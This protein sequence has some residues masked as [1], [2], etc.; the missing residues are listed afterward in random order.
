MRYHDF[1]ALPLVAGLL[2]I[3]SPLCLFAQPLD[4]A[5]HNN[6]EILGQLQHYAR[7]F[8]GWMSLD[9]I[10]H[11]AEDS[12]P[13]WC[14]K[15]SDNPDE[16]EPEAA[17]LFI[18]QVHAEEVVG[19]EL[20]LEIMKQMIENIND[21]R[22]RQRLEGLEIY[23][24][25]TANPEGL[26]VVHSGTDVTYRKNKRDNVGDGVL[27]I[28]D[29]EGWDTSGVDLNRN[30][31]MHWDRGDTLYRP[32]ASFRYNAYRGAAP[33]SEPESRA[34]R[35]L[36][37]KRPFLYSIVYHSSRS[38]ANT[39]L[40]I[41]PWYW[42]QN[43]DIK[44][45][46]DALA[47]NALGERLAD[48]MPVQNF[49]STYWYG[50]STMRKGQLQDWFYTETGCIQYMAE[51]AA[52]VHP[53]E[54]GMRQVVADQLP[55]V[56]YLMDLALGLE[57]L[58][59]F[60]TLTV[61]A[62][63][64]ETGEPLEANVNVADNQ[65]GRNGNVKRIFSERK[66]NRYNGRFDYLVQA[67]RFWLSIEKFGH[68]DNIFEVEIADGERSVHETPLRRLDPIFV[69]ITTRDAV[70][71]NLVRSRI[72]YHF[73]SWFIPHLEYDFYLRDG[74]LR[75]EICPGPYEF[76]LTAESYLPQWIECISY[77]DTSYEISMFHGEIAHLENFSNVQDWQHQGDGWGV[78]TF[79]GR[80]C[81]TESTVGDYPT[82]AD[83]WL[84]LDNVVRLDT[85]RATMRIIHLPYSEPGFDYQ[86]ISWWTNPEDI[87][88]Q[89]YSQLRKY[90]PNPN[91]GDGRDIPDWDTLNVSLDSLERGE[92]NVRFGIE[93]DGSIGE[94][95]WLI[96]QVAVFVEGFV[97]GVIEPEL[98][99]T[100]FLLEP[101]FPNPFNSSVSISFALSGN[102]M[103]RLNVYDLS[104][105][106]V[107]ELAVGRYEAGVRKVV[108]EAEGVGSGV[109]LLRLES[110]DKQAT[111]KIVLIR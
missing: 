86:E 82:E 104:G 61:M 50:Q 92:L 25:V 99:P 46:P 58:E 8:P 40:L 36:A 35:D 49:D 53:E 23:L 83:M 37:L 62:S 74:T 67:G 32:E 17:L 87:R 100:A 80:W 55:A 39:E 41:G 20:V 47:I 110:G 72:T 54:E 107:K 52:D 95:G 97:V 42:Q 2:A 7:N 12:L 19:V 44:R 30:F 77:Q 38:G 33:F 63:D 43:G 98:N 22:M 75:A 57:G 81:L 34:I 26:D 68:E 31:G 96:D 21:N 70:S 56:W 10:G 14:V 51:I 66:S 48:L 11:S 1:S 4:E 105:R 60:G 78:V 106:L 24:I 109:Y 94:D 101:P 102:G 85:A 111:Q 103:A 64:A 5:Y 71:A 29:G 6:A 3:L 28:N 15:I 59:G 79:E 91:V 90:R 73:W 65:D 89:R 9:S 18:G 27:R 69:S 93:S 84:Q 76:L 108:W 88:S 16:V 45:P 13:I